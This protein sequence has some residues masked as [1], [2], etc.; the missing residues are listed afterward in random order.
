MSAENLPKLYDRYY[1]RINDDTEAKL[2][3]K[4]PSSKQDKCNEV[5][6]VSYADL[7]T[8]FT[9]RFY[10]Y[11]FFF[12]NFVATDPANIVAYNE[13]LDRLLD[14]FSPNLTAFVVKTNG[15]VNFA[16]DNR[17]GAR[18][19][20]TTVV[21]PAGIPF[22]GF[23]SHNALNIRNR[24]IFNS[25]SCQGSSQAHLSQWSLFNLPPAGFNHI[26]D[27]GEYNLTWSFENGI[28][29]IKTYV[30]NDR[31][32]YI[33]PNVFL[34]VTPYIPSDNVANNCNVVVPLMD[35]RARNAAIEEFKKK[36]TK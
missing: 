20:F 3:K 31:L 1:L 4:R 32:S 17:E 11:H 14:V 13:A 19:F 29:R 36:L 6:K 12:G 25:S 9:Q 5:H 8:A 35:A 22:A 21:N 23:T 16:F 18:T 2:L 10:D 34:Q 24:P 28:W 30:F 33:L 27:I 26:N 7:D 15:I